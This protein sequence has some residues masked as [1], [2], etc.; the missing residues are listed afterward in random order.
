MKRPDRSEMT[1]GEP[2]VHSEPEPV[3]EPNDT[4]QPA[5]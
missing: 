3:K 2:L 4:L 5:R 1:E